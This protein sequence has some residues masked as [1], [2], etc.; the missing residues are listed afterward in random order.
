MITLNKKEFSSISLDEDEL[1]KLKASI[2]LVRY[3]DLYNLKLLTQ[4]KT[5]MYDKLFTY[6][7][8]LHLAGSNNG[9]GKLINQFN[10]FFMIFEKI[11]IQRLDRFLLMLDFIKNSINDE[12]KKDSL[13]IIKI[14]NELKVIYER[15]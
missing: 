4:K 2:S 5:N 14:I 10:S 12:F 3:Q 7:F 13:E 1:T 9:N 8:D 11:D 6:L 15:I